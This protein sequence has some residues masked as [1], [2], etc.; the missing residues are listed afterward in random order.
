[1]FD[2]TYDSF[3]TVGRVFD[4]GPLGH[5]REARG[6]RVSPPPPPFVMTGYGLALSGDTLRDGI[7]GRQR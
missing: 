5:R 4:A 7:V 3:A 2:D 1:M 6:P